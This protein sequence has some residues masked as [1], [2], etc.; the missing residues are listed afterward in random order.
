MAGTGGRQHSRLVGD[1]EV[2]EPAAAIDGTAPAG[3]DELDLPGHVPDEFV[4]IVVDKHLGEIVPR[5]SNLDLGCCQ[6][7]VEKHHV[8]T[9]HA[10]GNEALDH[11]NVVASQ[12]ANLGRFVDAV[13]H[14]TGS[15][16]LGAPVELLEGQLS[17][18]IG[19]RELLGGAGR[20]GRVSTL[21]S[22]SP[23]RQ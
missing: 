23:P 13:A 4:Q 1:N 16:R 20:R 2:I 19:D 17:G 3:A 10:E 21:K 11:G 9:E 22:E 18:V 5:H 7:V 6:C 8:H 14:Q 12:Q 15:H